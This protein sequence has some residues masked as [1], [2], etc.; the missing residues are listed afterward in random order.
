MLRSVILAAARSNR[1]ERLVE[2]APVSRS[3]VRRFI[4]G[5]H[6]DDALQ[7]T[8][9]L[10]ADGLAVTIDYLGEDTA[11]P[12]QA[13]ATRDEYLKILDALHAAE[14]TPAAEVS[15]K[16][17]A[18]GQ[19]F[20]EKVAYEH[21]RAICAK[22]SEAGT[23]VTLD[24]EDHTTTDSTL[25]V[26]ARLRAEFPT[27]GAVVQAY[28]RRTE[29][30]CRELAV[31]GSR[32]R[33]CK[34]AYKEPESVAYQTRLDVDK[35]YV[36]CLNVLMAGAGY[37]M[38]AT[39]DPRL[40]GIGEDRAKWYERTPDEFEFQML[41][42]VRPEEQLRL[43]RLGYTVRVYLPY[44]TQWYAYMMRRLAERP[45]NVAFLA[46]ALRSRA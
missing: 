23:T 28:L 19:L 10:A 40:I 20:D 35:S 16:L 43:A 36:R 25:E 46:R 26:L 13:E 41:Y 31:A 38:A 4:A 17:S 6:A 14:L 42:G 7:R 33:L 2:T 11:N 9:E 32:V 18:L 27:T 3:I 5:E 45:A 30:D 44:G 12:Q 8:R 22:A 1:V 39:H 29:A 34:G 21:A 37:P 24:A 15:L